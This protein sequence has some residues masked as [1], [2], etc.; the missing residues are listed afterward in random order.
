VNR[1]K[2]TRSLHIPAIAFW[3]F[4]SRGI[5]YT[6]IA[7][8]SNTAPETTLHIRR[9]SRRAYRWRLSRNRS[10]QPLNL[11]S[12]TKIQNNGPNNLQMDTREIS[13]SH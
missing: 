7:G 3:V 1:V 13:P 2:I 10:L 11:P 6:P 8:D 5:A 12:T 9:D 4:G